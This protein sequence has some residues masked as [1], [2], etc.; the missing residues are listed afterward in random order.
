MHA[1]RL[2]RCLLIWWQSDIVSSGQLS[3]FS[4]SK[5]TVS[6]LSAGHGPTSQQYRTLSL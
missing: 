5:S 1:A 3:V 2:T 4:L 6:P